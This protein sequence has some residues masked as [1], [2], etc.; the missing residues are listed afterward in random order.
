MKQEHRQQTRKVQD[1]P[2]CC[3]RQD[4]LNAR[5]PS[6]LSTRYGA[7]HRGGST[8]GAQLARV[9]PSRRFETETP[10]ARCRALE[11]D[12]RQE[13]FSQVLDSRD[14][15]HLIGQ[16]SVLSPP[17]PVSF[18]RRPLVSYS[19]AGLCTSAQS[20][21]KQCISLVTPRCVQVEAEERLGPSGQQPPGV[22]MQ[23]T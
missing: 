14:T 9:Y 8:Y 3:R 22:K 11:K 2:G 6:P 7:A 21:G 5:A 13:G 17:S 16:K 20:L 15:G 1:R 4:D 12:L 10:V 23:R 19:P 18:S